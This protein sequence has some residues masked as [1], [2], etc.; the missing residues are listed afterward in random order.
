MKKTAVAALILLL[1]VSLGTSVYLLLGQKKAV[2][3]LEDKTK[4]AK[5]SGKTATD[6]KEKYDINI[7]ALE[8]ANSEKKDAEAKYSKLRGY[9]KKAA[10]A[11]NEVD[12]LRK[13]IAEAENTPQISTNEIAQLHAELANQKA[14]NK[15][16]KAEVVLLNTQIAALKT[17]LQ[18]TE[19]GEKDLAAFKDLDLTP[20]EILELK[21]KR[22][23][24]LNTP[25]IPKST[26]KVPGKLKKPLA[27]PDL[28]ISEPTPKTKENK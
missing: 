6:L 23:L 25:G 28:P 15:T 24:A 22:P 13:K 18:K 10:Y 14:T 2:T 7:K 20:E 4:L 12:E 8:T 3:E 26:P 16:A 17:T 21:K 9:E 5:A 27:F 19:Q 1:V 11:Q